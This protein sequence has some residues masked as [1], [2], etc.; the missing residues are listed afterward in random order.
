MPPDTC[1]IRSRDYMQDIS[2]ITKNNRALF[3]AYDQGLEHG[4]ADFNDENVNP[5]FIIQLAE[6][7]Y[8]SGVI[9]QKGIAEKYYDKERHKTPLIVKLNGKTTLQEG[10]PISTKICLVPEAVALGAKAV[11]YTIYLGSAHQEK[12]IAEFAGV[13]G[14]AHKLNIPTILWMYP[15][16]EKVKGLERSGEIL[17]YG[18]RIGLELGADIIKM[19]YPDKPEFF[20]RMVRAAGKTR[21][22]ISGGSKESDEELFA[23][24]KR[25]VEQGALG[26]AVGRNIWQSENALERAKKLA[27]I[28]LETR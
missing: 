24:G 12:M 10:E 16:G 8:F 18:A 25:G 21:I 11:G 13:V 14:A 7:G 1:A 22:V 19:Y 9:F 2:A 3:L 28:I 6:S 15:R 26:M 23:T 5:E 4:P 27:E 17:E 20:P